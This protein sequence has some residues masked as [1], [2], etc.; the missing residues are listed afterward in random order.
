M[1]IG[2]DAYYYFSGPDSFLNLGATVGFRNF[3]GDEFE[4]Q[5]QTFQV[6]DIQ[7]LPLALAGRFT[8]LSTLYAG[9][10]VGYALALT[11]DING[12]FYVRPVA[13]IDILNAIEIYLAYDIIS[14]DS[15]VPGVDAASFGN[16]NLGLLFEL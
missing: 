2:A 9:A 10:D 8:L 13:G 14:S 11:E 7:F 4:I 16:F 12:G 1:V 3:F 5:G 6:D 15:D